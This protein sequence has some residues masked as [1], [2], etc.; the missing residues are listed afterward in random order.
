ME[1]LL[2]GDYLGSGTWSERAECK[3][4]VENKKS[5]YWQREK[6]GSILERGKEEWEEG[7]G[8]KRNAYPRNGRWRCCRGNDTGAA[9]RACRP[10]AR[11]GKIKIN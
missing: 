7:Q 4:D 11:R 5:G 8:G 10:N 2:A 6:K 1:S 9:R 3:A